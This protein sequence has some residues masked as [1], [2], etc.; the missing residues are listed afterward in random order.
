MSIQIDTKTSQ[1]QAITIKLNRK[2]KQRAICTP[3]TNEATHKLYTI[4]Y[5]WAWNE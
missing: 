3:K 5:D 1:K 4:E 2:K